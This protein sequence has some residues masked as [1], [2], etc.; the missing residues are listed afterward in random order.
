MYW[1]Y[2]SRIQ[3]RD[4][5]GGPV[6]KNLPSSAGDAGSI[7]GREVKIPHAAGQLS[8]RATTTGLA[9]LSERVHVPQTTEPMRPGVRTPQLERENPPA[10]ARE[11]LKHHNEEPALQQKIPHA[12]T[13]TPHATTKTRRSQKN[14]ENKSKKKKRIQGSFWAENI[15]LDIIYIEGIYRHEIIKGISVDEEEKSPWARHC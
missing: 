4:F 6:V 8:P 1:Y 13:K 5:P 10:T 9:R 11:K 14:K 2:E 12:S 7:P 3:G 15:N